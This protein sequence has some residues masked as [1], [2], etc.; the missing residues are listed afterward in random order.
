VCA[1]GKSHLLSILTNST[2]FVLP[3]HAQHLL[4]SSNMG[5]AKRVTLGALL[6]IADMITD[7]RVINNYQVSGN[8]SGANS[9]IA[10]IGSSLAAQLLMAYAQNKKKSKGVK[11]REFVFI[12][13][14]LKPGVDAYRVAT[15]HDDK[16]TT[17]NPLF[18]MATGKGV[19][20]A[21][22][23]IPGGLLQAYMF[24]NSPEKTVFFLISILIST[25]T[26]GFASAMISFDMDVS[27]ANRKEVPLFYGYIKDS[28]T[29]RGITFV[30]LILL[31][32]LHNLSRTIGT[33]LLLSVSERL[34]FGVIFIELALY[35]L[36]KV[37]RR[38]YVLWVAGLEG[39]LKYSM[40]F[41]MHTL[42]KILVD[43]TGE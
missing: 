32:S 39:G 8:T 29:E 5:L 13:T 16:D 35:H 23:S 34:T 4:A 7:M 22:E 37:G 27:V 41:V 10:M 43:Y 3:T 36:Y 21:L 33:A 1:F 12:V 28:N 38:D 31:A 24:I 15:G 26:T 30:L 17:F 42:F 14:C 11:L 6:S 19:E 18:E 20:L 25:L 9:L 2:Q 40:A